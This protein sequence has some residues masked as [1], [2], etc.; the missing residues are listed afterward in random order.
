M[1]TYLPNYFKLIG[2]LFVVIAIIFS[3]IGEIDVHSESFIKSFTEGSNFARGLAGK[4][5]ITHPDPNINPN[6]TKETYN[7][8]IMIS[9]FFSISGFVLYLF[10]KEKID[11]EYIQHIRLKSIF[12]SLLASWLIYAVVKLISSNYQ[13]DGIYILQLQLI[14]YVIV[15]RHNKNVEFSEEE[16]ALED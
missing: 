7:M 3:F 15:F 9:L 11:D 14:I 2:I 4:S 1:K 13:L 12:Q 6:L 5:E 10:S 16:I 8:Y